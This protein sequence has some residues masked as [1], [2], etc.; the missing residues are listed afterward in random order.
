MEEKM[1]RE[2]DY[3]ETMKKFAEELEEEFIVAF[4]EGEM[5]LKNDNIGIKG[6]RDVDINGGK[7]ILLG[8]RTSM[9]KTSLALSLVKQIGINE[10]RPCVY[11]TSED[12]KLL[13]RGLVETMTGVRILRNPEWIKNRG[14][15]NS[16][17]AIKRVEE[18]QIVIRRLQDT[19]EADVDE[20]CRGVEKP[21]VV[22]IDGLRF[23]RDDSGVDGGKKEGEH[24]L[25]ERLREIARENECPILILVNLKS[26]ER[27]KDDKR[28]VIGDFE[29]VGCYTDS[30]DLVLGLYR[31]SYYTKPS[32]WQCGA[33]I[34]VLKGGSED[35]SCLRVPYDPKTGLFVDESSILEEKR[36]EFRNKVLMEEEKLE[37]LSAQLEDEMRNVFIEQALSIEARKRAKRIEVQMKAA[38]RIKK[39]L[40]ELEK[41]C[42][43]LLW[44]QI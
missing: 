22:V 25:M 8:G 34:L 5:K 16:V 39:K 9:G 44:R 14:I 3:A 27:D 2:K 42:D 10:G 29:N 12:E 43:E 38:K 1:L 33:E 17:A 21:G 7:L 19:I 24:D 13:M 35:G 18:N 15:K 11:F 28:P 30:A 41:M 40:K 6:F 26:D 31:E 20:V 23:N 4:R 32:E 36:E 37:K